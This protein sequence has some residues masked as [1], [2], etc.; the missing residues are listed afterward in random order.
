MAQEYSYKFKH[1]PVDNPLK[2]LVPYWGQ[3]EP[4][5]SSMEFWY[6]PIS[7]LMHAP[8]LFDWSSIEDKLDDAKSR[9]HQMVIRTYLEYPGKKSA[10]PIYLAEQGVKITEY[11]H[12]GEINLTPDYHDPKLIKA[13]EDFVAAFGEKFDG[14]P[15]VGYITMGVLGHWGEWHTYPKGELFATKE[16]QTKI[17]DAFAKAFKKTKI[18]MRYP[19]GK[20]AWAHAAN[21]DHPVGYHDDSFAWATLDTGK[22]EDDWFFEPAMKKAGQK[23]L[24]K[25]KTQP[26]GGEIR[27]EI[28]GCIFDNKSCAPK[29]QEFDK[30]VQRL[31]VSWLMDS[32]MFAYADPPPTR[33]RIANATQ[34]V[35][36]MGYELFIS[37]ANISNA[38]E[39]SSVELTIENRGVAPFYYDWPV[40]LVVLGESGMEL[41]AVKTD[42][43]L[44]TVLPGAPQKWVSKIKID[45]GGKLII[46]VPNPMDGGKPLRFANETQQSDG[47]MILN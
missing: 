2:G 33:E 46:S 14:D 5:P 44:S 13:M 31:H 34:Q 25:W 42:W 7:D 24:D 28:W 38:G 19:A 1:A 12:D 41:A 21:D 22:E 47:F 8:D 18:L 35:Q 45:D 40:Q 9:G 20:D 43:K 11:E 36:K 16:E 27:P 30:C 4:F 3:Q 26:I 15:R 32:G 29:G 10:M 39:T 6:F 37:Q 23:A 17:Q